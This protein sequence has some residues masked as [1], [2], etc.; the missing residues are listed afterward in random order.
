MPKMQ[1]S[2]YFSEAKPDFCTKDQRTS[3]NSVILL[4]STGL[5]PY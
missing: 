2:L 1:L 5:N 3:I 4:K